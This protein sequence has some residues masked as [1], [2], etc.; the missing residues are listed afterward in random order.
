LPGV[1]A[2]VDAAGWAAVTSDVGTMIC[3]AEEFTAGDRVILFLR[4]ED[5]SVAPASSG[6][7]FTGT[8][9]RGVFQGSHWECYVS[10]A[11]GEL[12]ATTFGAASS[13][14]AGDP[15]GVSWDREKVIVVADTDEASSSLE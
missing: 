12:R 2:E 13:F 15:V 5:V 7:E 4:P 10:V 9:K 1:V 8:L 6:D 3:R 11:E 14:A